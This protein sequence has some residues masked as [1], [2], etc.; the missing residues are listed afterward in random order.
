MRNNMLNAYYITGPVQSGKTT[1]LMNLFRGFSEISGLF[2][3]V[4]DDKRFIYSLH[5]RRL[6]L[7]EADELTPQE[8]RFSTPNYTFRYSAFKAAREELNSMSKLKLQWLVIDEIGIFEMRGE[9][10]EP[11]LSELLN[12]LPHETKI[13]LVIREGLLEAVSEKYS[14][15]LKPLPETLP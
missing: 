8:D 6:I 10:Y 15:N 3:P 12:S 13:V 7:A 4:I 2:A 11:A 1:R 14:L 5:S 9:G